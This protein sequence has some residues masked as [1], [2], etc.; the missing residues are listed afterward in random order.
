M[1]VINTIPL[2]TTEDKKRAARVRISEKDRSGEIRTPDFFNDGEGL[3]RTHPTPDDFTET[4]TY[5]DGRMARERAK[6]VCRE[7]PFRIECLAWARATGQS[8]VFGAEWLILGTPR[9][10]R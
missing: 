6:A 8:G 4:N 9:N 7:C 5:T 2:K 1:Q 3:C 10:R